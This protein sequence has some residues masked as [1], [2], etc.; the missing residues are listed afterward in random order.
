MTDTVVNKHITLSGRSEIHTFPGGATVSI[1]QTAGCDIR[2]PNRTQFEDVIFAKIVPDRNGS[3]WHIVKANPYFPGSVNGTE[4]NRVHYLA[5]GDSIEIQGLLWRFNIKDGTLA[6]PTV[7]HIHKGGK[8][9]WSIIAAMCIALAI[10]AYLIYDRDRDQLT[11]SMKSDI[12]ASLFTTRVDSLQLICGDSVVESYIYAS[13]P[14]GTAFITADSLIVTARHCIQPWLNKV[15]PHEFAHLPQMEDWPIAKALFTETENQLAGENLW[16]LK[17]FI[18]LT[19]ETGETMQLS[20]EDFIWNE[21]DD[22]IVETGTYDSPMYWRSISHRYNRRDM[23]LGDVAIAKSDK[24]GLIP[25]ASQAEI[26]RLLYRRGVR[27]TFAGH[28]EASVTG[29]NLDY[30]TDELRMPLTEAESA[31]DR[32]FMIV[33]EGGLTPGFSGGPAVVRDG[34]GFKAVGV[35]SVVD[36]KNDTRS[37]SVPTSEVSSLKN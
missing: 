35:I 17:T 2:L 15:K 6:A 37:Y 25:L 29:N 20:S 8:A 10:G 4:L 31:P 22:D 5:D 32:L 27:I 1:G 3:G 21:D 34:S 12:E 28:P 14:V 23:M 16:H 30:K 9:L 11:E 24:P 19:A 18:T 13:V 26:R 33:H 36:N 7:T